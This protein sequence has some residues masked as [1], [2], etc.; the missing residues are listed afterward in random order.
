MIDN[1]CPAQ[2]AHEAKIVL[3]IEIC[4]KKTSQIQELHFLPACCGWTLP[5]FPWEG[6]ILVV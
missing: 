1:E 3:I 6:L 4:C 2:Q 5:Y